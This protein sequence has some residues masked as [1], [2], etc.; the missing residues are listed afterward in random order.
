MKSAKTLFLSVAFALIAAASFTQTIRN[1][2][3]TIANGTTEIKYREYYGNTEIKKVIIPSS[4][5]T[6]GNSAFNGCENLTEITIPSSVTSIGKWAFEQC[7]N[8]TEITIP[9]S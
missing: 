7:S 4:V 2:V 9:S 3:L 6:I 5:K 8:L 1:G